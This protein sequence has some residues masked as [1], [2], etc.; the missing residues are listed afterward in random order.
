M[1]AAMALPIACF[2]VADSLANVLANGNL[3]MA[4]SLAPWN[5]TIAAELSEQLFTLAPSIEPDVQATR[6]AKFALS[7]EPTAVDAVS[8]LGFQADLKGEQDRRDRIFAQSVSLS[9]RELHSQMWAIENA[10]TA[11]DIA[12][13]LGHYDIA[14]STS[15]DGRTALFPVLTSALREPLVRTALTDLMRNKP[16]WAADF[17]DYAVRQSS[18]PENTLSLVEKSGPFLEMDVADKAALVNNLFE[19][20]EQDLAWRYYASIRSEPKRNRSRDPRFAFQASDRTYFD[21]T[22]GTDPGLSASI[23]ANQKGGLFDFAASPSTG[24]LLLKQSQVLPA[25]IY[26]IEGRSKGI[27]QDERSRPYWAL[28]CGDGRIAGQVDVPNSEENNGRFT[29]RISVGAGCE[30]QTLEFIARPSS[31]MQGLT[32]Q[33]LSISLLPAGAF[34]RGG[35]P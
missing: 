24:G 15:E 35:N 22:E 28:Q 9:R 26:L 31:S 20:G 32:G 13:A 34:E 17:V 10:I 16:T 1:L 7:M 8:V 11:G 6:L 33:I 30:H 4:H 12:K 5:G 25:G 18:R 19:A 29:G 2:S 14:L 27:E 21:W 23:F 3:R